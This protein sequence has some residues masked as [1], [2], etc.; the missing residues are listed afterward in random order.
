MRKVKVTKGA[1]PLYHQK[2]SGALHDGFQ[3][4]KQPEPTINNVAKEVDKDEANVEAEKGEVVYSPSNPQLKLINGK[5]H[6]KGGTLLNLDQ[7]DFVFSHYL[8]MG[9]EE[10]QIIGVEPKENVSYADALK[11]NVKPFN[12]AVHLMNT[13]EDMY[14]KNTATFT[15]KE[16]LKKIEQ[17][18]LMQ[19]LKKGMPNGTPAFMEQ[20]DAE[21][22][23]AKYGGMQYMQK[24]GTVIQKK[25]FEQVNGKTV[26]AEKRNKKDIPKNAKEIIP[27]Q[28]FGTSSETVTRGQD[29]TNESTRN[30]LFNDTYRKYNRGKDNYIQDEIKQGRARI[31]PKT[32][33]VEF[34]IGKNN[35]GVKPGWYDAERP[36]EKKTV[37]ED[38]YYVEDDSP[39][40][41]PVPTE[42]P[43]GTSGT[44]GTSGTTPVGGGQTTKKDDLT[45]GDSGEIYYNDERDLGYGLMDA[46]SMA[47]PL[48]MRNR[49]YAPI[50]DRY[51]PQT[52]GKNFVDFEAARYKMDSLASTLGRQ[53][54][55][56]GT[57]SMNSSR[58]SE[59]LGKVLNPI[60]ESF[61]NEFNTNQGISQQVDG[62]N[63]QA[64]N[65][66]KLQNNQYD[67]T[68][69]TRYAQMNDNFDAV[70]NLKL[71]NFMEAWQGAE[72][73]RL[74]KTYAN[75]IN[76]DYSI[77][78]NGNIDRK[79]TD[80]KRALARIKAGKKQGSSETFEQWYRKNGMDK[81]KGM[82]PDKAITPWAKINST[83][84]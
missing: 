45:S 76:P 50:N 62:I 25:K 63:M 27:G 21:P 79:A 16:S 12:K 46:A 60:N 18:A 22:P 43:K 15:L 6:K 26:E 78:E 37:K 2:P 64:I 66:A 74:E 57:S 71:K 53:N 20:P 40:T 19:E 24:A 33:K 80:A 70:D 3:V 69:R 72:K 83:K 41:T 4:E 47:A 1:T 55:L 14:D 8:K 42:T 61:Q 13:S 28:L 38:Y 75:M 59:L 10:Q 30:K 82:T 35:S 49:K 65:N 84:S 11:Q 44:S 7:G 77:D 39:T 29:R 23:M 5:S 56:T 32:N 54:N 73:G 9:G 36:Y 31:N 51:N 68:Y 48:L 34:N 58:N 67:D 17:L 81:I 52:I